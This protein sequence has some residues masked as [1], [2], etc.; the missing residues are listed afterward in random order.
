VRFA[1]CLLGAEIFA[2][3]FTG[4]V[5]EEYDGEGTKLTTSDHSFG[6]GSDPL[7]GDW[8]EEEERHA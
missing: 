8:Y 2:V 7:E 1:I 6:F 5:E 4:D 3:E